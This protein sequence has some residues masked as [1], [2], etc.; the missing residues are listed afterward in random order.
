MRT[1]AIIN[2]KARVGVTPSPPDLPPPRVRPA[3]QRI[4]ATCELPSDWF[5]GD[6]ALEM[7]CEHKLRLPV[8]ELGGG[9]EPAL[10]LAPDRLGGCVRRRTWRA[11]EAKRVQMQVKTFE[12]HCASA[13]WF[14][15]AIEGWLIAFVVEAL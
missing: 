8:A 12:P 7:A 15:A 1:I 11:Q 5:A 6:A 3:R 9:P 14:L 13:M 2:E 10:M 4:R